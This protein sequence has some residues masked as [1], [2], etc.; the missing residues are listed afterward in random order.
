MADEVVITSG[1]DMGSDAYIQLSAMDRLDKSEVLDVEATI[2]IKPESVVAK[3]VA[4]T[5]PTRPYLRVTGRLVGVDFD[6]AISNINGVNIEANRY[7][8]YNYA[9]SNDELKRF[10][11]LGGFDGAIV[12]SFDDEFQLGIRGHA[13]A[14]V[15]NVGDPPLTFVDYDGLHV[16][17][18]DKIACQ[19]SLLD[20]AHLDPD[21][22]ERESYVAIT[23]DKSVSVGHETALDDKTGIEELHGFETVEGESLESKDDASKEMV[24]EDVENKEPEFTPDEVKTESEKALYDAV[25]EKE[26]GG[27]EIDTPVIEHTETPVS[28]EHSAERDENVVTNN[29]VADDEYEGAEDTSKDDDDQ[30]DTAGDI[31]R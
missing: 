25:K 20:C 14:R 29:D 18:I 6:H 17:D 13:K 16:V 11:D 27:I 8:W 28:E 19:E 24:S 12:F 3:A 30:Y 5:Y 9:L 15:I 7:F 31:E 10:V 21:F 26:L 1:L 4:Q 2:W 22:A 23:E